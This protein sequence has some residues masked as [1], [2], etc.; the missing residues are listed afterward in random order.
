MTNGRHFG[1]ELFRFLRQ[2]RK[3]NNREWFQA[4]KQRYETH[5]RDPLL[6]FIE[7]I[8]PALRGISRHVVADPRPVGGSL[9][10]IYRDTRFSRDKSP[11]KT[12]ASAHFR[13]TAG[14][15]VHAP[16]FYLHLEPDDVFGGGG[17]FHPDT[18]TLAKVR[19]HIV[20]KPDAWTAATSSPAFR[21]TC[22]LWGESLKRAPRGFD[23][24]HPLIEELKRKDHVVMSRFDE[25]TVCAPDFMDR[26]VDMCRT[27]TP[28]IRFLTEA[29]K[30]PW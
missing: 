21:A 1:P 19:A 24:D 22:T 30:L 12:M 2:L 3:N 27:S 13:H 15:D 16:G 26:Y 11:Y 14:R 6:G 23:P 29:V 28:A 25:T 10:R 17:L 9:F 5:V 18:A 8:G 20:E 4:N 7:D